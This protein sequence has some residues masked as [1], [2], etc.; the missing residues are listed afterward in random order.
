M[1]VLLSLYSI[2]AKPLTYL[3]GFDVETVASI[4]ARLG[5]LTLPAGGMTQNVD[6]P[7]KTMQYLMPLMSVWISFSVSAIIGVYWVFQRL[8]DAML[9]TPYAKCTRPPRPSRTCQ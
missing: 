6:G 5:E 1:P 8:L 7:T 2:I 4:G 3:C 9:Q